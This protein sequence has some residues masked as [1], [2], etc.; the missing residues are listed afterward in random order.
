VLVEALS[1]GLPV[2][3]TDCPVGPREVL[4][5]GR[6]GELVAVGDWRAMADALERALQRRGAPEGVR[7]YAGQFTEAAACAAY[8][9]LFS[10]LLAPSP[11]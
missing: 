3:S 8:R 1:C 5:G 7:E 10:A 2:V 4:A 9:R 11:C 6:Y